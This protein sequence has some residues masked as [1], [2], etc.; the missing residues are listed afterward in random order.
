MIEDAPLI[1]SD[2]AQARMVD[3]GIFKK[4]V[5]RTL[6]RPDACRFQGQNR[7][8]EYVTSKGVVV[9]VVYCSTP[10]VPGSPLYVITVVRLGKLRC[11][12]QNAPIKTVYDRT[13]DVAYVALLSGRIAETVEV[14]NGIYYDLDN[15]GEIVGAEV[16][17]FSRYG[18]G[19]G[20][21]LNILE[22]LPS[23]TY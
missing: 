15:Y 18:T 5:R 3:R 23:P 2:H 21:T 4:Q 14:G 12:F 19:D 8:A 13:F 9:R 6:R 11:A 10:E 1:Y 20:S 17:N 7:I 22:R 16:F